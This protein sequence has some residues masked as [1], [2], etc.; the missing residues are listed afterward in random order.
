MDWSNH[1]PIE[2]IRIVCVFYALACSLTFLL[3]LSYLLFVQTT[4]CLNDQTTFE[5]FGFQNSKGN[6]ISKAS[7]VKTEV[8]SVRVRV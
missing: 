1:A 2:I 5:R 3:P 8:T 6:S 4:N 7:S